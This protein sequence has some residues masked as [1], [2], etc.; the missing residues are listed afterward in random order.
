V[1][2]QQR[3]VALHEFVASRQMAP[4][5]E[6]ALPLS[7]RP[8]AAVGLDFAQW[9]FVI[10]PRGLPFGTPGAP[11]QSLSVVQSS[12]VG[13]QPLGGWQ[14]SRPVMY[15]AHARLQ[16]EP[17]HCGRPPSTSTTPPSGAVPPH[18]WPA[19]VHIPAPP[20]VATLHV[21]SVAPA[22]LVHTPPQ[23][24]V[25]TL[26]AS[27]FCAQYELCAAQWPLVQS[28]EQHSPSVEH[29]LPD[30]LQPVLSGVHVP[31]P[32]PTALHAPLQQLALEVHAWLSEMHCAAPHAPCE[33]TNVQH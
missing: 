2:A 17:P 23:H 4:A 29:E 3:S 9:T 10:S 5:G 16:H 26:H 14:M 12:P 13:W 30:V 8:T 18:A 22:A 33:Q 7:Q 24:S 31:L 21:P 32:P 28:D 27:P 20:P 15:G 19:T 1:P 11:Q 6:H 25:P